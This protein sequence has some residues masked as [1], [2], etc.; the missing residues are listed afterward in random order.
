MN[1]VWA[2]ASMKH[3]GQVA[4]S[5]LGWP[6]F[7]DCPIGDVDC[8]Y[9]IG[10]YDPPVYAYTLSNIAR[11]K[12]VIIHWCGS[13]VQ[14]LTRPD[15]L[16]EA[17]H[18]CETDWLAD[19]LFAKGI[20]AKVVTFPTNLHPE[21]TP[22]PKEERIAVY[23]GNNP[24][25]YGALQ[26]QQLME[27]LP[28]VEWHTYQYGHHDQEQLRELIAASRMTLRLTVHDGSANTCREFMEAG[29]LA[30]CTVPLPYAVRVPHD[31]FPAILS[32]IQ[33]GMKR[34][35]PD[36]EQAAFYKEFNSVERYVREMEAAL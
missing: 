22:L 31:D 36:T 27:C 32:A 18:I 34:S 5:A 35:A 3:F 8:V 9:V 7:I 20:Q 17:T 12:R 15:M 11:A 33:D 25:H 6:L 16:P 30:I 21:V 23:F 10:L 13:D 2:S 4:S 19:E 24:N 28:G 1:V 26:V 29:R 14:A